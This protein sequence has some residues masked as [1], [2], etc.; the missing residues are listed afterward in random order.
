MLNR[1][2]N[3]GPKIGRSKPYQAANRSVGLAG[4]VLVVDD[5]PLLR[6]MMS[7]VLQRLGLDV[8][9]ASDG[10]EAIQT[11]KRVGDRV[12]AVLLDWN[13]PHLSGA[14]TVHQVRALNPNVPVLITSG[15]DAQS[16]DL[17][18]VQGQVQGFLQKPFRTA[19]LEGV[20]RALLVH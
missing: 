18:S 2:V 19:G 5:E 10:L 3:V 20:L 1:S 11:L 8:I 4:L 6:R 15:L 9:E 7:R 13:M 14:D 16:L 17:A 12:D